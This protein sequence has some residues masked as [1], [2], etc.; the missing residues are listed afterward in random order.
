MAH[1]V[2]ARRIMYDP[3]SAEGVMHVLSHPD[4][5]QSRPATYIIQAIDELRD[6]ST[7]ATLLAVPD[8]CDTQELA[9]CMHAFSSV[10]AVSPVRVPSPLVHAFAPESVH[11]LSVVQV[12]HFLARVA[13]A[14]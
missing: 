1:R 5:S 10:H 4:S 8:A 14:A 2:A 9:Q 13:F 7:L 3:D 12:R 6:M 11:A